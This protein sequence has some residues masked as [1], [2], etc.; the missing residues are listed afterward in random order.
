MRS[1]LV[2][3]RLKLLVAFALSAVACDPSDPAIPA[4]L[5]EPG[6]A[7]VVESSDS[8]APAALAAWGMCADGS[9]PAVTTDS[10]NRRILVL[11]PEGSLRLQSLCEGPPRVNHTTGFLRIGCLRSPPSADDVTSATG[12]IPAEIH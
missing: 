1:L 10:E 7:I 2:G 3:S 8:S 12:P 9:Q 5:I 6:A 4:G 11:C